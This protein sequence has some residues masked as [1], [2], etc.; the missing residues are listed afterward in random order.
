LPHTNFACMFFRSV[1]SRLVERYAG[2]SEKEHVGGLSPGNRKRMEDLM[3][4]HLHRN[5]RLDEFARECD[6]S[7]AHF[8]RSFRKSF[9]APVHKC[10]LRFRMNRAK[11]LLASDLALTVIA[12]RVGFADQ[13][14]FT[15][16]FSRTVGMPPG[17][18]RRWVLAHEHLTE[19][20]SANDIQNAKEHLS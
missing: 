16:C 10:L 20:S 7:V 19:S 11:E 2:K 1:M 9:G 6:L 15:E 8:A 4:L 13:A 12:R 17:R 18:F 5:M 14:T 3:R